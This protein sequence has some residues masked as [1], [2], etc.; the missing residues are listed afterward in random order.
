MAISF[1][2]R[3]CHLSSNQ[4]PYHTAK[5][6]LLPITVRLAVQVK[7]NY[8]ITV[9]ADE[10]IAQIQIIMATKNEAK[11]GA[12]VEEKQNAIIMMNQ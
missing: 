3:E 4:F 11:D 6:S 12:T 9:I 10:A 2:L 7:T 1:H 8:F 5:Y